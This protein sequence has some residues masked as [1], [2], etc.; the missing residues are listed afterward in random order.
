VKKR[1]IYILT[2]VLNIFASPC[3]SQ[4]AQSIDA[5]EITSPTLTAIAG[6]VF[7]AT[8][9]AWVIDIGTENP[10][11]KIEYIDDMTVGADCAFPFPFEFENS[12]G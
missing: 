3:F 2:A 1:E 11:N 4:S 6:G 8:K 5:L 9:L 10:E 7:N 12:S